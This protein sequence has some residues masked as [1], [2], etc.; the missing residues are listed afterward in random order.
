[1]DFKNTLRKEILENL[2]SLEHI[3]ALSNK[4]TENLTSMSIWKSCNN[5]CIFISFKNEVNT[6]K[7]IET[8][9]K[10]GK[11]V[12]A[13]LINGKHMTF[14][15]VDNINREDLILNKFGILE[16]PKHINQ[17]IPNDDTLFV[18]PGVS[19]TKSGNRLG[20]GGGYYDRYLSKN[21]VKN[22]IALAF[23]IQ[24]RDKIPTES[25]DQK[26]KYVVTE[27]KIYGGL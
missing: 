26:M 6:D 1:M 23:N 10:E 11:H 14:H 16:P 18:I 13:P 15:R 21:I 25:W 19:F 12:Y 4:I 9:K 20:R 24:I 22:S 27:T 5:I 3:D 7:I 17:F 2:N 8:A